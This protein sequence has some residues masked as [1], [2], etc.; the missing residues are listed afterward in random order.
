MPCA[1]RPGVI[2]YTD[3]TDETGSNKEFRWAF[4]GSRC[5]PERCTAPR[6]RLHRTVTVLAWV[7][8]EWSDRT[9]VLPRGDLGVVICNCP[10]AQPEAGEDGAPSSRVAPH[11]CKPII[12]EALTF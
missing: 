1:V 7:K 6:G 5:H 12:A 9:Y 3:G 8:S 4:S 11:T 10:N 2:L